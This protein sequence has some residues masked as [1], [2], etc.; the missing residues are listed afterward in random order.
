MS[1]GSEH[2]LPPEVMAD[3]TRK[4]RAGKEHL[5][6]VGLTV[7]LAVVATLMLL[8]PTSFHETIQR[9]S[10]LEKSLS[11]ECG[12]VVSAHAERVEGEYSRY[13]EQCT[14]ARTERAGYA[15]LALAGALL[16]TAIGGA[17]RGRRSSGSRGESR[18]PGFG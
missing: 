4:E 1:F 15:G 17:V 13:P 14:V 16:A 2:R 18:Q 5:V 7:L 11:L 8:L 12:S 6:W 9:P 10:G 3:L